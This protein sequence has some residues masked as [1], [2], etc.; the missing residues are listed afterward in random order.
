MLVGQ[1]RYQH[2]NEILN[3]RL[4]KYSP[5]I[6]VHRGSPGAN[7]IENT[8]PS[9]QAALAMGA[10]MIEMDVVSSTDGVLYAFHDG[11]EYR[12]LREKEN[13]KTMSSEEI[14]SLRYYNNIGHKSSYKVEKLENVLMFFNN[15]ELFNIDR[16]WDIFPQL[17][18]VFA[19]Y[20]G[21]EKQ[22]LLKS[23]VSR[24]VL[25][26]L[27]SHPVKYMYMPIVYSQA[28]I[29]LVLSYKDV[30]TV[31]V[32]LIAKKD[33]D[34]FYQ[35]ETISRIKDMNLF[36]WGNA[37]TLDDKTPLFGNLDDDI[38]ITDDPSKGWGKMMEKGI[39]IIQTD[40]PAI[41]HKYRAQY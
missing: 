23:P 36:A 19:K 12:L 6:A 37:I 25:E 27:S 38:S 22:A 11:N 16:A 31:G 35:A 5:L 21:W 26:F 30:N 39:D 33:S 2:I 34:D 32:E 29:D 15:G 1:S 10:D 8:I 20:P 41:L 4:S 14:D 13:I 24:R 9:Y 7:I 18:E 3:E 28:D 17:V 40:W